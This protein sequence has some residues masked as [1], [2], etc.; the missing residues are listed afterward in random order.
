[1]KESSTKD[2]TL[3]F[4]DD[5]FEVMNSSA[6][7]DGSMTNGYLLN[8]SRIIVFSVHRSSECSLC[9]FQIKSLPSTRQILNHRQILPVLDV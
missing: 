4:V 3:N 6:W 1:M 9:D 7:P 5:S 2:D 8:L